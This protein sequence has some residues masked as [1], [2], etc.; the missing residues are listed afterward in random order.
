MEQ[1]VIVTGASG[2][3][4]TATARAFQQRGAKLSWSIVR[5]I[6]SPK[7]FLMSARITR[8]WAESI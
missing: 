8:S 7:S 4:G 6:A 2:K 1:A 3:L 5:R